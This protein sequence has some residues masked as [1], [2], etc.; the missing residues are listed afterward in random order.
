[1]KDGLGGAP[2][3]GLQYGCETL[4][5]IAQTH[6]ALLTAGEVDP[7]KYGPQVVL[8]NNPFWQEHVKAFA[9]LMRP[10]GKVFG[11]L[12]GPHSSPV[13]YG[14]GQSYEVPDFIDS[15]GIL[16]LYG[17]YTGNKELLNASRWF[18]INMSPGGAQL[19]LKRANSFNGGVN[20]RHAI[21]YFLLLDP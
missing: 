7:A 14:E 3:E 17:Q 2:V 20:F 5:F 12:A 9:H 13:W 16:G 18:E 1:R 6:L 21:L 8:E 4:A 11:R 19:L 15:W 10:G